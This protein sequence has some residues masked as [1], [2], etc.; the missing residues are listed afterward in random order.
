MNAKI[1]AAAIILGT[2]TAAGIPTHAQSTYSNPVL[3]NDCPDPTVIDDRARSGYFYLYS[4]QTAPG[5]VMNRD[6]SPKD[7]S[8][9]VVNLPIYKSKDLVNWE[10][11]GDGFPEGRPSWLKNGALWAPDINYV[12]G[13]YVL[14]YALGI[15][16]G[17]MES[18]SGVA[19][20]DSPEGPF[21]DK[22]K[23]VDFK[24]RGTLNSIDPCYFDDGDRK[25]LYWGS[26][27]GGIFGIELA[28][29]G[30]NIAEGAKKVRLGAKNME[31]AFM[32]KKD[33]W[34]YLFASAGTCCNGLNSTYHIV[35]GRSD[36]PLGPFVGPDG[37]SFKKLGYRYT[38]MAG[39]LDGSFA[40]PGHNSGIITDD[41]GNDWMLYHSY[42]AVSSFTERALNL[43]QIHWT[44]K[45]WPYFETGE[46]SDIH[47]APVFTKPVEKE[48]PSARFVIP[49]NEPKETEKKDGFLKKTGDFCKS[50]AV[51]VGDFF[52]TT[53]SKDN[54]TRKPKAEAVDPEEI[55]PDKLEP[56]KELTTL[57]ATT[58]PI[59]VT[60]P[61]PTKAVV[62][63]PAK[64][65][66]AEP[67]KV[68]AAEPVK[69][70]E[71]TSVKEI[72]SSP[73]EDSPALVGAYGSQRPVTDKELALFKKM[74][75]SSAMK[76]TPISVSTQVVSGINY[77]FI[78]KC[79]DAAGI[80]STMCEITIYE[81]LSG[82]PEVTGMRMLKDAVE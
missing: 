14:Y 48:A 75:A 12:N 53:F 1:L 78:S 6:A 56:E 70:A 7:L 44:Q 50:T 40:G 60:E 57:T 54:F 55:K 11:V 65:V 62:A 79:E 77:K 21:S 3:K 47:L 27:G 41:N 13:R 51:K 52:R 24:T 9:K 16:G 31:G 68:A 20:A 74:T 26:I 19:V 42:N 22:G 66:V 39:S 23:V 81:P 2:T 43:D 8:S 30:I 69:V 25:F 49:L 32:Y 59:K 63:E 73:I 71:T 61:E 80:A 45:G 76:F 33:G 10:F 36:N 35:V 34:Y 28:S 4:T 64:A 46:P 58:E 15:W 38:I 37:Q 29:D 67:A 82:N 5:S 72:L 17:V 18:G